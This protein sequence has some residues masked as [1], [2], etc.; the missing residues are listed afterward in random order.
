[1]PAR[2]YNDTSGKNIVDE[3]FRRVSNL[4][5]RVM[6]LENMGWRRNTPGVWVEPVWE[7]NYAQVTDPDL[8][9]FAYRI[10]SGGGVEFKGCVDVSLASPGNIAFTLP[11]GPD[12]V[13]L[14]GDVYENCVVTDNDEF[15]PAMFKVDAS[16]GWVIFYW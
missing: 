12:G 15:L 5:R 6:E 7:N 14:A 11:I 10:Y 16:T 13:E 3:L 4:E 9:P 2:K 8:E 1:M